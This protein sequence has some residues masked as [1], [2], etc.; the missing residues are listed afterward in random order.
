MVQSG[1]APSTAQAMPPNSVLI[2][3][4]VNWVDFR[5]VMVWNVTTNQTEI[6]DYLAHW[7]YALGSSMSTWQ[8]ANMIL[9]HEFRHATGE[10]QEFD[11]VS[12]NS[13]IVE[14]CIK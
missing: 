2:N 5:K 13:P 7:N 11:P 9:L 8:L 3:W 6:M 10:P 12:F 4:D 14:K 1:T